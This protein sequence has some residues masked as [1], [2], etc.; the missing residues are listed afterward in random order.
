MKVVPTHG[1]GSSLG[2]IRIHLP[3][4]E[5]EAKEGLSE[6]AGI[7]PVLVN[8]LIL[9]QTAHNQNQLRPFH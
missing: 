5:I 8:T 6:S 1:L 3:C 7:M 9:R 4:Q 2:P